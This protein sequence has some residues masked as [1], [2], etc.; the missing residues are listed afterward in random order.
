MEC[1]IIFLK[2][3]QENGTSE[4]ESESVAPLE[5]IASQPTA[6]PISVQQTVNPPL[7]KK[8]LRTTQTTCIGLPKRFGDYELSR[9]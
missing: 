6:S 5:P 9:A 4:S 8:S 7:L 2:K 1:V 3:Y